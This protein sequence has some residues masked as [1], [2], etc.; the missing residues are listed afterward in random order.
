MKNLLTIFLLTITIG[1]MAFTH[2]VK[3]QDAFMGYDYVT[4]TYPLAWTTSATTFNTGTAKEVIYAPSGG[5]LYTATTCNTSNINGYQLNATAAHVEMNL[6][7]NSGSS[8]IASIAFTGSTNNNTTAGDA[9]VVFSS[10]YPF[11]PAKVI[12]AS[13]V[14]FPSATGSW[15]VLNPTIP[16]GAKSMRIYRR[17]YYHATA[18]ATS[19]PSGNG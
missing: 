14:P 6:T 17:V 15:I 2:E 4:T 19:T 9:G 13:A 11:N 7:A 1:F 5:G 8:T 12:G 3:G 10:E 16:E 18:F